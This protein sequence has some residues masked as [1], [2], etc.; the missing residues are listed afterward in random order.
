MLVITYCVSVVGVW[1]QEEM[2]TVHRLPS[3]H[4]SCSAP[5][6]TDSGSH[7][8]MCAAVFFYTCCV[9]RGEAYGLHWQHP[10]VKVAYA[11]GDQISTTHC[12][13]HTR[14]LLHYPYGQ[15]VFLLYLIFF[16][17]SFRG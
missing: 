16:G 15:S 10:C 9:L 4:P 14:F 17:S 1:V 3:N 12:L 6:F 2:V 7:T 11:P 13:A 5:L 8:H